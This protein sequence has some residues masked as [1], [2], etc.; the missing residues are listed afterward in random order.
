MKNKKTF[1]SKEYRSNTSPALASSITPDKI[2][3]RYALFYDLRSG[4]PDEVILDPFRP[5]DADR[6]NMYARKLMIENP[7]IEFNRLAK[8][9]KFNNMSDDDYTEATRK[10]TKLSK[11]VFGNAPLLNLF[12]ALA[13]IT[14]LALSA[15]ADKPEGLSVTGNAVSVQRFQL[16]RLE[17]R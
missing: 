9:G 6:L 17:E 15:P 1:Y 13:S 8:A 10:I 12:E 16:Q 4:N 11:E 14:K 5:G 7:S 3:T 2:L